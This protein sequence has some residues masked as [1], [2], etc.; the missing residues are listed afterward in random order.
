MEKEASSKDLTV[1]LYTGMY[2]DLLHEL[3]EDS[4]TVLHDI[5]D[6]V[7]AR[8]PGY[9]PPAKPNQDALPSEAAPPT[10]PSPEIPQP[11]AENGNTAAACMNDDIV[12]A[13]VDSSKVD[14]VAVT[15]KEIPSAIGG[16]AVNNSTSD[17]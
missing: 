13:T 6:W 3:P 16:D 12:V 7:L 9:T 10:L 14:G 5:I 4:A 8:T 17:V 1:K 15:E 11:E 2:H